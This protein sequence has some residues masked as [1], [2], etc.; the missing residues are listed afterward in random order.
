MTV[1]NKL[2]LPQCSGGSRAGDGTEAAKA[3]AG[4]LRSW[5]VIQAR[6]RS[7]AQ[8]QQPI[9][10]CSPCPAAS[11]ASKLKVH[12]HS[13][14]AAK[15]RCMAAPLKVLNMILRYP[16]MGSSRPSSPHQHNKTGAKLQARLTV[17]YYANTEVINNSD[18]GFGRPLLGK[19]QEGGHTAVDLMCN[20][21][22]TELFLRSTL[23]QSNVL[24]SGRAELC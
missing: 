13:T 12:R 9:M 5:S 19:R 23:A 16:L 22:A 7:A 3:L 14:S 1:M 2:L 17:M 18:Y 10:L 20:R 6:A 21:A 15:P 8:S 4:W 11:L 24:S